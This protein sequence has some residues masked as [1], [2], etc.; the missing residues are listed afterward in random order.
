MPSDDEEL[1]AACEVGKS[2]KFKMAHLDV[3]R[4]LEDLQR[5]KDQLE[6]PYRS[7]IKVDPARDAKLAKLKN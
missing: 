4:W 1:Q 2:L 3:E 7:A 5:D 6:G